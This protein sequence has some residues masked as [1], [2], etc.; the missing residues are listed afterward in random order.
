MSDALVKQLRQ[1]GYDHFGHTLADKAADRIEELEAK[2]AM[3]V[4]TLKR[5][6]YESVEEEGIYA[7][8]RALAEIEGEK[9]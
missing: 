4:E 6:A 2:L 9:E 3:A 7:A 5:I 8:K 1:E